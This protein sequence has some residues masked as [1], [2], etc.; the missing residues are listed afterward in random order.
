MIC[1]DCEQL[2]FPLGGKEEEGIFFCKKK[3][4]RV[5]RVSEC[6]DVPIG[7]YFYYSD[8]SLELMELK[9]QLRIGG[10]E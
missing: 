7:R 9:K 4:S 1:G 3:G 6:E 2:A 8:N 5:L 10:C